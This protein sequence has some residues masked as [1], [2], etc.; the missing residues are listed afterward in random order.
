MYCN[1][2]NKYRKFKTTKISYTFLKKVFLL[3][4]IS[5]VMNMKKYLKKNNLLKYLK[6]LV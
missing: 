5:V 1:V 3:F 4:T 6:F 2:C